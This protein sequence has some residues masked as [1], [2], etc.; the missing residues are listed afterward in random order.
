MDVR[1]LGGMR[2]VLIVEHLIVLL[3]KSCAGT[4]PVWSVL[5]S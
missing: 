2:Y 5:S 3:K 4:Q 1:R